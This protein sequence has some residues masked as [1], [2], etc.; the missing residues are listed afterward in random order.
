[1][2][3]WAPN[4]LA[5]VQ[6]IRTAASNEEKLVDIDFLSAGRSVSY[7]VLLA[8]GEQQQWLLVSGLTGTWETIDDSDQ[9]NRILAAES[10]DIALQ[11]G[12]A[13]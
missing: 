7:A 6:E 13:P 2:A 1:L 8:A 12:D 10:G 3:V 9:V 4:G 5:R 11:G